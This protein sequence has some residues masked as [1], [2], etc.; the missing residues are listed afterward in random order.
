MKKHNINPTVIN[1][2]EIQLPRIP[3][4][5]VETNKEISYKE[6]NETVN[7]YKE[8]LKKEYLNITDYNIQSEY[9][10]TLLKYNI[11]LNNEVKD[12]KPLYKKDTIITIVKNKEKLKKWKCE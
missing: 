9:N 10:D 7:N 4:I 8:E 5:H 12:F 3:D 11:D 6:E 2:R 1:L